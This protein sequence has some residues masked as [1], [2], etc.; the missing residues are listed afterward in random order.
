MPGR[1]RHDRSGGEDRGGCVCIGDRAARPGVY[2]PP[3]ASCLWPAR[4]REV[5]RGPGDRKA[6]L[7]PTGIRHKES[8]ASEAGRNPARGDKSPRCLRAKPCR[9]GL[10]ILPD[11]SRRRWLGGEAPKELCRKAAR[12]FELR[13][14]GR[15]SPHFGIPGG[16]RSRLTRERAGGKMR[17]RNAAPLALPSRSWGVSRETAPWTEY[18]TSYRRSQPEGRGRQDHHRR[19]SFRMPCIPVTACPPH[20]Q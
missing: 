8:E 2:A 9:A 15:P 7:G 14:C 10:G 12:S 19:Q 5:G 3:V 20:R 16:A 4:G 18:A 6:G 17:G 11:A 13:A 1:H